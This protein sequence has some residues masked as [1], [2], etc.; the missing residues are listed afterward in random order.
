MNSPG[1]LWAY[2]TIAHRLT[3]ISPF[4]L[5]YGRE[6]IVL[7][8]IGMPTLQNDLPK[9]SNAEVVIKDL[10][11]A[12]ELREAAAMQIASYHSRIANLYNKRMKPRTFQSRDLVLR[13]FFVNT[14]DPSAGKFQLNLEGAYITRPGESRSYDLDKLDETPVLRIWNVIHL[15]RYY[16]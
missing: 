1:V 5:A 16:Q 8:K 11:M 9:Q 3:S 7:T 15:K 6:A 10:D 2:R 14:A 13:N 4:A 12:D